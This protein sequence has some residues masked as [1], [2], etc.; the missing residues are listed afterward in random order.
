MILNAC[1]LVA[2][3]LQRL[4]ELWLSRR[5]T[6][7]LLSFGAREYS[8]G[9]YP[10]I[11]AVHA[12]WIGA[13]WWLGIDRTVNFSWLA[14]FIFIAAAR[15]WVMV[16][17]GS[18]WTTRIIVLQGPLVRRGPYRFLAH[19]NYLVVIAETIVLPLVFG[20]RHVAILFALLVGAALVVRIRA[21][22]E[23][24]KFAGKYL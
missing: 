19:P 18:R 12:A 16:S 1:I 15:F 9:H 17:L 3:T 7:Q 2:V 11:I 10:F 6:R 8:S 21:E 22:N 24:L 20:L 4:S 5:N 13:L 23:A 14:L